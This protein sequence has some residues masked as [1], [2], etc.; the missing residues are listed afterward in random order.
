MIAS[1]EPIDEIASPA[2]SAEFETD[3]IPLRK[4]HE[5]HNGVLHGHQCLIV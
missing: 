2:G 1:T 4:G 3:D 5:K